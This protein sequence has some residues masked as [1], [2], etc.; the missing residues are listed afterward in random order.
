[1]QHGLDAMW[2]Y[3]GELFESDDLVRGLAERGIA[4][5]P[6]S[7]RAGWDSFVD[8]VLDEATLTRPQSTWSPRGGRQG[9][10]TEA[11]GYL[12]AEMQHLHRA[13]P[14]ARW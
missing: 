2:P 14:G 1:M 9:I 5:D 4:A 7:L 8:S 6:D 12:L 13:H 11:F 10:H 3:T